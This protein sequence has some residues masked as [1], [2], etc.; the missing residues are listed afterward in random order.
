M[1]EVTHSY[2]SELFTSSLTQLHIFKFLII[3]T[4][5][6]L[7]ICFIGL[8]KHLLQIF[9]SLLIWIF[10]YYAPLNNNMQ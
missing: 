7:W 1:N 9:L 5:E 10:P 3:D 6:K 8:E 4:F 2:T